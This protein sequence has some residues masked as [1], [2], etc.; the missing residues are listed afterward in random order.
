MGWGMGPVSKGFIKLCALGSFDELFFFFCLCST[1][2]KLWGAEL[3]GS[4]AFVYIQG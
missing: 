1:T 4:L 2:P 3:K